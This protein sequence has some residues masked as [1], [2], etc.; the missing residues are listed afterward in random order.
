MDDVFGLLAFVS[1]IAAQFLAVVVAYSERFES[2][3][4]G[5][6]QRATGTNRGMIPRKRLRRWSY[7]LPVLRTPMSR[8]TR[9]AAVKAVIRR[10]N[11][12]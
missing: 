11:K 1:L 3:L 8:L 5:G 4:R 2:D 10:I 9:G 7:P 6:Q 12:S